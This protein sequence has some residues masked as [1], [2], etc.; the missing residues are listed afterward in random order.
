M[1]GVL[2]MGIHASV[3]QEGSGGL[4]RTRQSRE[5]GALGREVR[6]SVHMYTTDPR[7]SSGPWP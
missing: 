5:L 7:R 2:Q 6:L 4:L 1:A 3:G